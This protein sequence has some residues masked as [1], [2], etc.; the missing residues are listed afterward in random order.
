[1]RLLP[2]P[3]M[4]AGIVS[5]ALS[6]CDRTEYS[7]SG[8]CEACGGLLS[9]YDT[10]RKRFAV[11]SEDGKERVLEVII[12]RSYCRSC[13]KILT[14]EDPF[15]PGT[16][17]GA[18]VVDLCRSLA[19]TMPY[20]RVATR[21]AQMGV[22]VDRWSV[23]SYCRSSLPPPLVVA[24][25]GMKVPVSLITLSSLAGMPGPAGRPGSGDILLAC[26]F[27]S[28]VQPVAPPAGSPPAG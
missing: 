9:G 25:F 3:P 15:Y 6:V 11:L 16:R 26:R 2:V 10:R 18:P 23:R 27:P 4:L 22:V 28:R 20:N 24:L 1:M 21:L 13:K 19:E 17:A 5:T 12:H 14:P 8:P 7:V